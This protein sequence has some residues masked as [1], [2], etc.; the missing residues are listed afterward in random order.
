MEKHPFVIKYHNTTFLG[1]TRSKGGKEVT[2]ERE[3]GRQIERRKRK[4]KRERGTHTHT[5]DL[6]SSL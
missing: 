2:E 6:P 1:S 3:I 5:A 4:K